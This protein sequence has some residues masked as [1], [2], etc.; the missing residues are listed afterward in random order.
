MPSLRMYLVPIVL[1]GFVA[2]PVAA[3]EAPSAGFD[4]A[5][6][7][8]LRQVQEVA[9]S[10]DGSWVA[11]VLSVPRR[12]GRDKDG[13]VWNELHLVPYEGGTSRAYVHGEV[14][15]SK[16][17]FTPDSRHV[18]Y[19]AKRGDDDKVA[20]W[21]IPVAGGESR[22]LVAHEEGITDYR[23][24]PD[25]TR[26]AFLAVEA[27]SKPAKKLKDQGYQQDVF[28][29]NWRPRKLWLAPVPP[30]EPAPADPSAPA[31]DGPDPAAPRALELEGSVFDLEWSPEGGRLAL[32]IAPRPFVDDG[33]MLKRVQVVSAADGARLASFANPGKLGAFAFSPDGARLAM[34]TADDP[35]DPS[36]GRLKVAPTSGGDLEDLLPGLLGQVAHIA[37]QDA[38]TVMFVA[39]VG[40]EATLGDVDVV[41]RRQQVHARSGADAPVLGGLSL[42]SSGT[43]SALVGH[44]AS[45]PPEAFTMGH[46][47]AAPRRL[48]VSNPW[49]HGVALARQEVL[50][51]RARDGVELEGVLLHPLTPSAGT[52]PPL[53]LMVHGGPESH[54]ANG[55]LTRFSRPGQ[56]AAARGYAVLYANYRGS[57]GR[58]VEFSKL[59]QGDAAGREFDDL[60]DA[61]R[62]LVAAGLADRDRVGITGGSYGGYATAW[63]STRY[64]EHF[65]AGVM[66]VGV[67]NNISKGLTT[68]I[69]IEDVMVH[70]RSDP[71]TRWQHSLERSP[72]YWAEQSRTALLIAAGQDDTRV[73]PAESLQLYRV[74]KLIGKTPVRYVRYP[75][76]G[77]GNR[78][79]AARDDF[80]RRLMQWM[81]HFVRDKGQG[82]PPWDLASELDFDL[83][84]EE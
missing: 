67:S 7:A 69:P 50:R 13:P 83:D 42:S 81:D 52:P 63:C 24:S 62:H 9:L 84:D 47:D 31:A 28:E 1:L 77:H 38:R 72:V 71:W 74:L 34:I 33:Y 32:A 44:T 45:H 70:M 80:A 12:P 75:G 30:P 25:G 10:P 26:V 41:T 2:P 14:D 29:E 73:H 39:E 16:A 43:R 4:F 37:W 59:G 53:L 61:V 49:L 57:T 8:A 27:A 23:V 76:E 54:D 82:L 6:L 79:A 20:L 36:E 60:V 21:A 5:R 19:L 51:W 40:V 65:R 66:S 46:G 58:G 18:T 78:K 68:E 22:K 15:V 3:G 35:N 64:T 17:R 48:T 56:L 11:Y 55:W